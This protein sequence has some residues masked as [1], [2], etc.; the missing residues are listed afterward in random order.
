MHLSI[1]GTK[2]SED[3]FFLKSKNP[4]FFFFFLHKAMTKPYFEFT[5]ESS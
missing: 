3:L 5:F 4:V 1:H 2:V